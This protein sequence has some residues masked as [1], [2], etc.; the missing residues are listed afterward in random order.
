VHE[1]GVVISEATHSSSG[2]PGGVVEKLSV[3]QCRQSG[4]LPLR[5]N[6]E[7]DWLAGAGR[8]QGTCALNCPDKDHL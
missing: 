2:F 4:D 8:N 1:S 5:R 6:Q 3:G 7:V